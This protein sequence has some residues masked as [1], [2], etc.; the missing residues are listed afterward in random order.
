[1]IVLD[2]DHL[3]ILQRPQSPEY[4]RLTD[5]M[6]Q[7][8]DSDFATTAVSLEE[9]MRGW[10]AAINRARNVHNQLLYYQRLINVVGFTAAGM[11]LRSISRPPIPLSHCVSKEFGSVRWTSKLPQ[12]R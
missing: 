6:E 7:S 10:L 3:S 12:S 9:Q 8:A 5:R 1:M 11:L 4:E 2:T